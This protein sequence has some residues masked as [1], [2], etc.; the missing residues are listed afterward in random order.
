MTSS[1]SVSVLPSRPVLAQVSVLHLRELRLL[2]AK[3]QALIQPML[4]KVEVLL[5]ASHPA[6]AS[7]STQE[8][9]SALA[10]PA[11]SA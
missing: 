8:L 1:G 2:Q 10:L 9:R 7:E 4:R 6:L 5:T 11:V 3:A